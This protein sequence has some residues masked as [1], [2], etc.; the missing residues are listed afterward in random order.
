VRDLKSIFR[1][2]RAKNKRSCVITPQLTREGG[3]GRGRGRVD[4]DVCDVYIDEAKAEGKGLEETARS[5][6]SGYGYGGLLM[7]LPSSW[8]VQT[9]ECYPSTITDR[10]GP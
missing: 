1:Y 2:D 7:R 4:G 3:R 5:R 10:E 8:V 6:I 9:A